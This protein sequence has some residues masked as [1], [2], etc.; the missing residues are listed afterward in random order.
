MFATKFLDDGCWTGS[1]HRL[2]GTVDTTCSLAS[3][4]DQVAGP[5][6]AKAWVVMLVAV[7]R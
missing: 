4:T 5:S 7:L 2:L 6:S 3:G 1:A